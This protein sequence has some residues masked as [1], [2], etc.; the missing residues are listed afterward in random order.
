M[1]DTCLALSAF[2]QGL[3]V[4]SILEYLLLVELFGNQS[5]GA[6]RVLSSH[7]KISFTSLDVLCCASTQ[8]TFWFCFHLWEESAWGVAGH[9]WEFTPQWIVRVYVK[10]R[11]KTG[12]WFCFQSSGFW[13][14]ERMLSLWRKWHPHMSVAAPL[15]PEVVLD[16]YVVQTGNI[17]SAL[18]PITAHSSVAW[19]F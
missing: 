14:R 4:T 12:G 16:I 17:P 2:T 1:N 15:P 5:A 10:V 8:A 7:A 18:P 6:Y 19:T 13:A 3:E 11:V 9:F